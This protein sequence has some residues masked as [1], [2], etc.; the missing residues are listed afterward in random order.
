MIL[1]SRLSALA[2]D[3]NGTLVINPGTLA[4]GISGGTFAEFAIHPI[5]AKKLKDGNKTEVSHEVS[6]RTCV[7]IIRI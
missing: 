2:K 4:K 5:D 6:N 7:N 3:V 1:P